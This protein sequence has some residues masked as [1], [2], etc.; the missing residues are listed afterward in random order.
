[1]LFR[2][3]AVEDGLV[4]TQR[5]FRIDERGPQST[6]NG[7]PVLDFFDGRAV[8]A[9]EPAAIEGSGDHPELND[10]I[11]GQICR[12]DLATLFPPQAY[13]C[14]F[15]I[16]HECTINIAS[17]GPK[18]NVPVEFRRCRVPRRRYAVQIHW[19]VNATMSTPICTLYQ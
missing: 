11:A 18:R 1:M 8:I 10:E 19:G 7:D 16:A 12:F 17:S 14:G 2:P 9:L 5:H 3:K 15:I 4:V 13:Q 6:R